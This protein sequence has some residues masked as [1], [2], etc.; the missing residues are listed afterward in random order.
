[1]EAQVVRDSLLATG[2]RAR[3][4]AGRPL[5]SGRE[6]VASRR[7]SL[8]FVHSHNEHNSFSRCSTTPSVHECYRRGE[9]IV[10]QQALALANSKLTLS[11]ADKIATSIRRSLATDADEQ[12]FVTSAWR[13]I[14]GGVPT[15]D[16]LVICSAAMSQWRAL[17]KQSKQSDE[18]RRAEVN[19]VQALL[20]HND[21]VTVR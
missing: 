18:R 10:P 21:F 7:R 13:L 16:E 6:R 8:Y 17:A 2:R 1:M 20:N 4:D 19:L 9:S 3:P 12:T 14:L 5:D 11:M 15:T